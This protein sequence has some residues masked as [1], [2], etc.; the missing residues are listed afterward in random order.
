MF[1]EAPH[2][3]ATGKGG[4]APSINLDT[5]WRLAISFT[6]R[7]LYP[8]TKEPRYLLNRRLGGPQSQSRRCGKAKIS[9]TPGIEPRQSIVSAES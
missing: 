2:A 6:L 7:P 8:T 3:D 9:A 1:N 5:I 4:I